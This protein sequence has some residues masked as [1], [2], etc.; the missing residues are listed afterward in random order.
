MRGL[1]RCLRDLAR[2]SLSSGTLGGGVGG[3]ASRRVASS[4]DASADAST[5]A[6]ASA[7][8]AR[9]A[10]PAATRGYAAGTT[11]AEA[12]APSPASAVPS[13]LQRAPAPR[14]ATKAG[15]A[16]SLTDADEFR[17]RAVFREEKGSPKKFNAVCRAIRGLRV[18][19]A[20]MQCSLSPKRYADTVRKVIQSAVANATNNHD[21]D[22]D[23]LVVAEA[24]V[25]KGTFIK[26]VSIHGRGR[27][28]TITK[29][30]T[31]VRVELA[32]RE[33]PEGRRTRV[34]EHEAPW[35]RRRRVALEKF[36]MAREAG[37]A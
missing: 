32:E 24:V 13:P 8:A 28:G 19:D 35:K 10:T 6:V 31:H 7:F 15:F 16:G 14:R 21:L 26:R 11:D 30:R 1:G 27:A 34:R 12:A 29:P 4:R 2:V 33:N 5:I 17:V 22:R 20:I 36:K 37:L 18:D 23:K 9:R 25:G 3:W